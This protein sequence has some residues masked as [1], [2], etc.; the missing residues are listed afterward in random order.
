MSTETIVVPAEDTEHLVD[1]VSESDF[2][3][4]VPFQKISRL[5]R[6]IVITEKIDGTNGSVIIDA[7]KGLILAAVSDDYAVVYDDS[8]PG[9]EVTYIVRAASRNKVIGL[10]SDNFGFAKWVFENASALALTLGTGQF[11]GEWYG[12]GIQRGYGLDERR[13]AFF[14]PTLQIPSC[15]TAVPVLYTGPRI[16]RDGQDAVAFYI[17]QLKYGGS[18]TVRGW[19]TPEG[20]VVFHTASHKLYKVTCENDDS[21]KGG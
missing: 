1:M 4:F 21:P 15:A 5:N 17:K 13:F 6:D 19:R 8:V 14:N 10:H 16:M 18:H 12:N 7:F 9:D 11:S 2:S 20:V 3:E